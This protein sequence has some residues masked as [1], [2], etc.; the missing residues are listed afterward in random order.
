MYQD[1]A[2]RISGRDRLR[3]LYARVTQV[4]GRD[5]PEHIRGHHAHR[6]PA[7]HTVPEGTGTVSEDDQILALPDEMEVPPDATLDVEQDVGDLIPVQPFGAQG[8]PVLAVEFFADRAADDADV[9]RR[10]LESHDVLECSRQFAQQPPQKDI[11]VE[12]YLQLGDGGLLLRC[13][14]D[15]P[16]RP[17]REVRGLVPFSASQ[18]RNLR[19]GF[20]CPVGARTPARSAFW[21]ALEVA[22][23]DLSGDKLESEL[24]GFSSQGGV[25]MNR[26]AILI[27]VKNAGQL[28]ELPAAWAG[29]EQMAAWA[30]DQGLPPDCVL[31]ITDQREP[32][33]AKRLSTEVR[34]IVERH[35]VDQLLI[36]FSGHG[37]N[38]GRREYWLLSDAI[39]DPNEAVNVTASEDLARY[40]GIGHV[41]I[42]SD[43]CRTAAVGIQAQGTTG[44]VL[45]PNLG[46]DGPE[47]PVDLF[48]ATSLGHPALEVAN[49]QD[50]AG[51]YVAMYTTT[52]VEVLRG[53]HP[54][55]AVEDPELHSDVIRPWPLKDFLER[56]VP[57]R[58]YQATHRSQQPDAR[59][60]SRPS[61]W[62]S[63]VQVH[64]AGTAESPARSS[65]PP[66]L[67][68]ATARAIQ[69]IAE[70]PE[71]LGMDDG[72][73]EADFVSEVALNRDIPEELA[74]AETA[75]AATRS[76]GPTHFETMCGFKVS[77]ASVVR[78]CV[79]GARHEPEGSAAVRVF[80][81][82][83]AHNTLLFF[84]NGLCA[85]LPAVSEFVTALVFD[86][87]EL[88][89]VEYAPSDNSGRWPGYQ[90]RR[91]RIRQ[92]RAIVAAASRVGEFRLDEEQEAD[93]IAEQMQFEKTQ[94]PSLA[95]YAAYAYRDQG[96]TERI[97]R[98]A[99]Y[100]RSD[101]GMVFFDI[102]LLARWSDGRT[103]PEELFPCV[104][105]L[106]QGWALL[107]AH[108]VR[109]SGPLA[110]L[111]RH[112]Q[113][114]SL[115][116]LYD[117]QGGALL[118]EALQQ[119]GTE[120]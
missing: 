75:A 97:R 79:F 20:S 78:A 88:V 91:P 118:E 114:D 104:P 50:S 87:N 45:F 111:Q 62:L 29:V 89:S 67:R 13:S 46:A 48:F 32:V 120:Q 119:G 98:M 30:S 6:A 12:V 18:S 5:A 96:R 2:A 57:V 21:V 90:E 47:K 33:T 38:N 19:V 22:S 85:L 34:R 86:R 74:F 52:L 23:L 49:V 68:V 39:V 63:K 35:T 25:N 24:L 66:R 16:S 4:L 102:G 103:P 27:G 71:L 55:V 76:F 81:V 115:W 40:C 93:R 65:P 1:P 106:S 113:L 15:A 31:K 107:P 80:P 73:G 83:R 99:D 11:A 110:S 109:Y 37:I 116:T 105:L 95:L 61:T 26:V 101:L 17:R 8:E 41:V 84:D 3:E 43:A 10:L 60:T 82:A 42:V 100:Q 53:E 69:N 7:D 44:S 58:V 28:P 70:A 59:I 72:V 92:L 64:A 14:H 94:D 51:S 54:E 117:A 36:Y 9:S 77:G 112:A 56:E 108:D